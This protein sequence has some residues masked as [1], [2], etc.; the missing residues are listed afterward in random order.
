MGNVCYGVYKSCF[1]A[2]VDL[3]M[4]SCLVREKRTISNDMKNLKMVL[5][6]PKGVLG[7]NYLEIDVIINVT[8]K[9]LSMSLV[10]RFSTV[11]DWCNRLKQ[12]CFYCGRELWIRCSLFA[13]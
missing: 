11:K 2:V 13:G 3:Y 5:V 7:Y 4:K 1:R 6:F 9:V 10:N 8:V 12:Q